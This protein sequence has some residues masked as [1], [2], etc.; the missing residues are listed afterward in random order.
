MKHWKGVAVTSIIFAGFFFMAGFFVRYHLPKLKIWLLAEI[1]Q[2][3]DNKSPFRV[4]AET[5][6]L[7]LLPLG[8]IFSDITA[9]PKDDLRKQLAPVKLKHLAVS[10]NW[11]ALFTGEVRISSLRL[12]EP[13]VIYI[14][15]ENPFKKIDDAKDKQLNIDWEQIFNVPVDEIAIEKLALLAKV[16]D[17]GLAFQLKDFSVSVENRY[18]SLLVVLSAPSVVFKQVGPNPQLS[19]SI[20]TRF[21]MD[22]KEIQLAA[23]KVLRENSYLVASGRLS[24]DFSNL[25][26]QSGALD[27]RGSVDLSELGD[28]AETLTGKF[29]LPEI[30][31][32]AEVDG[33][34]SM[35]ATTAL[36]NIELS[37]ETRALKIQQFEIDEIMANAEFEGENLIFKDLRIQNQAGQAR[38][39]DLKISFK[40]QILIS[41]VLESPNLEAGKLLK[42]LGIPEVPLHLLLS[43]RVPCSGELQPQIKVHCTADV[44]GKNLHLYPGEKHTTLVKIPVLSA[45][46]EFD[47]TD[48]GVFYKANAAFAEKSK[49]TSEGKI[50]YATGFDI[51]YAAEN[52]AFSEVE[53]LIGLGLEGQAN[54][55]GTTEGDSSRGTTKAQVSTQDLWVKDYLLGQAQAEIRYAEGIVTL[56]KIKGVVGTSRYEGQLTVN[57]LEDQLLL[58]AKIPFADLDDIKNILSRRLPLPFA[59]SGTGSGD[60]KAQGAIDIDKLDYQLTSSFYRGTVE[61]ESFDELVFRING[62]DGVATAQKVQMSKGLSQVDLQGTLQH[63]GAIDTVIVGRDLRLEQS[64][65]LGKLGFDMTGK[66]DFTMAVRGQLPDPVIET[67]GRLSKLIIGDRPAEDSNFKL[68]SDAESFVGN[69]NFIGSTVKTSFR[70]PKKDGQPFEFNFSSKEW[71]FTQLFQMLSQSARQKDFE[72]SLTSNISLKSNNGRIWSSDG[73]IQIDQFFIKRGELGLFSKKPMLLTFD[74][75]H[76]TSKDFLLEG[77]NSFLR[78]DSRDSTEDRLNATLNAKLDMGLVALLTPFLEDLRGPLSFSMSFQG[79]FLDPQITGSAYIENGSMKIKEF[80]HGLSRIRADVLFNQKNILINAFKAE[81]AGGQITGDGKVRLQKLKEIPVNLKLQFKD[82]NILFPEGMASKGSG[83]LG[84]TGDYFPYLLS[85]D[86]DVEQAN[87]TMEFSGSESADKTVKPS[88]FLPKFLT[89]EQS[90]VMRFD[91][92][93]NLLKPAIVKNSM[94]DAQVKGSLNVKGTPE[95]PLLKGVLTP[96]PGGKLKFRENIFEINTGYAEYNFDPPNNPTLYIASEARVT[97]VIPVDNREIKNEYDI[98]LL[99]QGKAKNPRITLESQPPLSEREI[100]SLLALGMTNTAAQGTTTEGDQQSNAAPGVIGTQLGAQLFESQIGKQFKDRLGVEFKIGTQFN[101]EENA[102]FPKVTFSKQWTPKF[103]SSASRTIEQ[104]PSSDVK[105]EYKF[106]KNTSAIG[107]WEGKQESNAITKDRETADESKIGLDLEYK[108]E[109]K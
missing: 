9:Q 102:S 85:M 2:Q 15:N 35:N 40:D 109:F 60:I 96:L 89:E 21:L 25:K 47:I 56:R 82:V 42:T 64:E 7:S 32:V 3:S 30:T 53:D 24:G 88:T 83:T 48:K 59:V 94:A 65:T 74:K 1:E 22:P 61:S 57:V 103:E 34:L 72:T 41:G 76:I 105:L 71:D 10:L 13:N 39:K 8:I 26:V 95:N 66:F 28:W 37:L 54:I 55:T 90:Q 86:Y 46:G 70:W 16:K 101:T 50:L 97:E 36:P 52:I 99:A 100:V 98:R 29:K 69:A 81:L 63:A 58:D 87:V 77:E 104:F 44:Q 17:E 23:L 20:N 108:I 62:K 45:K 79:P 75:G 67:N 84:I 92:N 68:V 5:V 91:L 6:N 27:L 73:Q 14:L 93:I 49:G 38:A 12:I 43:G 11:F 80:P 19:F 106:N 78:L 18:D 107:F 4:R 33:R 51:Q 31:G